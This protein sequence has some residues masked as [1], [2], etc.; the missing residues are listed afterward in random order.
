MLSDITKTMSVFTVA[1]LSG[2]G[3]EVV[4]REIARLTGGRFVDDEIDKR[5]CQRLKRSIGEIKAFESK[6]RSFWSRIV[7]AFQTSWIQY[8]GYDTNLE[9]GAGWPPYHE[10]DLDP[11]ITIGEYLGGL[12]AVIRELVQEG[13]VVLHG[14]GS[15]LF[16][17]S[18]VPCRRVLVTVPQELRKQ[19]VAAQELP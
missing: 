11:Y 17:P 5:L 14:H 4:G 3:S 6:H 12:K 8:G 13:N 1:G 18:S 19:K 16:I 9:W 10:Y 2:S 15:H 7:G